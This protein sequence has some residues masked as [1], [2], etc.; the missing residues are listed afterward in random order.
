MEE[1]KKQLESKNFY[2][3]VFNQI[4]NGVR[5][6]NICK[7]LRISKQKL[8]YYI[9]T[10]KHSGFIKRI[11]YGVWE[12]LK[13][14]KVKEVKKTTGVAKN[15]Y[16]L[17]E[18]GKVRAHGLQFKLRLPNIPKWLSR[19]EVLTNNNI[20]FEDLI[21]GGANR[22]QKL[23]FKGRKIWLTDKTII[24]YEKASY[25]GD[26]AR[27]AKNYAIYELKTLLEGL[28]RYLGVDL[29]IDHKYLFK[30]SRQHYALIKNTLAK[31]YSKEGKKLEIYNETGLWFVIDNSF[32][33]YEA[34]TQG[35]RAV[36]ANEKVKVFFN[37]LEELEGFTPKIMVNSIAQNALNHA[38]YS[39]NLKSHVASIKELGGAVKEL[40]K[41]VKEL[42]EKHL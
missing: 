20:P 3:Y 28:E 30:I 5:P 37:E 40:T 32:N 6:S 7:N 23:I 42:K 36:T 16:S 21:I 41:I 34:E 27:E 2:L 35:K 17:L 1:V 19:K 9:T 10:L 12:I 18:E 39:N 14:F 13:E 24:I 25:F 33:L 8:N 4:K 11:G 26:N 38:S 22:G 15:D 31:Q 29:K